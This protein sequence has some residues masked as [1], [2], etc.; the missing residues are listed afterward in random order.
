M[1]RKF[2][3]ND[4][5]FKKACEFEKKHMHRD[6]NTGAIGGHLSVNFAITSIGLFPSIKCGICGEEE[7]ITD[8]DS[9]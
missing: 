2:E 4:N 9:L 8:Y 1:V 3:L 7:V 6:D 5:E